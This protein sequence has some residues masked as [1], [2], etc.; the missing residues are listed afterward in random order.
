MECPI[1]NSSVSTVTE[2]STIIDYVTFLIS[3]IVQNRVFSNGGVSTKYEITFYPMPITL[4]YF[5]EVLGNKEV[6]EKLVSDGEFGGGGKLDE[7]GFSRL[8]C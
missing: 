4:D 3:Q 6:R 7:W 8:N 5:F 1:H 2:E